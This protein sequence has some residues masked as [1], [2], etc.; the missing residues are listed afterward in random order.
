[1]T[2]VLLV[3]LGRI[4]RTH[5][6]V[7]D[8][9]PDYDLVGCVEPAPTY[10]VGVPVLPDLDDGLALDPELVVLATPT[11]TH[12]QLA[13]RLLETTDATVLSEKPLAQTSAELAPLEAHGDRLKVAHHFAFSPEVEWAAAYV[14]SRPE[15]GPPTRVVAMSTD[16]YAD[17][18]ASRR[19]SLV[20][21]FVD[22]APNQLSVASA[23]TDGWR[24]LSHADRGDRA[25]TVL[26]HD[27]G[28]TV[29][30]SN[31]LAGDSSKH[32]RLEFRDG[33]VR[34][35]VEHSSMTVLVVEG[36]RVTRH[37]AYADTVERKQAHY[38]GLYEALLRRPDDPR[39]SV[40]LA[41]RIAR[42]LEAAAALP[43]ADVRW[44][45]VGARPVNPSRP[46]PGR[47]PG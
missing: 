15:L 10:D 22:S 37:A 14:A 17:L 29:L 1:V 20:S 7:L 13:A 39:L 35:E 8:R 47:S 30:S 42:L 9:L 33:Q 12:A 4:A 31:W 34:V 38:L 41:L 11:A 25:V 21:S 44:D 46:A 5:L 36:D 6:A 3:G 43:A 26:A 24:V 45:E 40:G 16:A 18:G 27:G 2:R 19:A 28:R 32:T 23:F